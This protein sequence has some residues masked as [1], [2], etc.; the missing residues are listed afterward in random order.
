MD[1]S[2]PLSG[3]DQTGRGCGP[4]TSSEVQSTVRGVLTASHRPLS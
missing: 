1:A 3:Q 2:G 4:G